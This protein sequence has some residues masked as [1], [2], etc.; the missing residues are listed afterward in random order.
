MNKQ[1]ELSKKIDRKI[2]NAM[3]AAADVIKTMC[4]LRFDNGMCCKGCPFNK[5]LY[6]EGE[7]DDYEWTDE[8]DEEGNNITYCEVN[9]NNI[10][11]NWDL[12]E[13]QK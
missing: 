3:L 8:D 7:Y 2:N 10:P 13:K 12:E 6:K 1:I 5:L 9:F 11:C 4:Q